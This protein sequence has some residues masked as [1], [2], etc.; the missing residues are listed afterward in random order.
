MLFAPEEH[1]VATG[2]PK[3]G[4][5]KF[6]VLPDVLSGYQQLMKPVIFTSMTE[7]ETMNQGGEGTTEE[8]Y[9]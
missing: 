4:T 5:V 7:A 3:E 1:D 2:C 8:K 9:S 6:T